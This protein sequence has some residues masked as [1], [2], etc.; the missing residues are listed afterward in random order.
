M[1]WI[2]KTVS[3]FANRSNCALW[4]SLDE[5]EASVI[6]EYKLVAR[7][8][9]SNPGLLVH[10]ASILLIKLPSHMVDFYISMLLLIRKEVVTR[11]L[12]CFVFIVC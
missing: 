2:L 7:P 11:H 4:V 1:G 6:G 8:W 9:D 12:F 3:F 5:F 10:T